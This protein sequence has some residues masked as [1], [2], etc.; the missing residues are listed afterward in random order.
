MNAI[1]ILTKETPEISLCTCAMSGDS[2][3]TAIDERGSG[4]SS[5]DTES[6]GASILDVQLSRSVRDTFLLFVSYLVYEEV[7]VQW[8]L[9]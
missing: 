8:C 1:S 6:A 2:K 3:K 5:P 4:P 7:Q 9:C